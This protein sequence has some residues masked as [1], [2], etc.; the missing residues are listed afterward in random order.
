MKLS[1]AIA[2]RVSNLLREKN[3]T[4]YRLEKSTAISHN[5]MQALMSERYTSVNFRTIMQ[6]IRG[7]NMTVAEFFNDP[8]FEREDLEID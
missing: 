7:L 6:I 8:I 1:T 5:T 2:K 4:Q 3:M